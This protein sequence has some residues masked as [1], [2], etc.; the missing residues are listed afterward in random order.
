MTCN[1]M[2]PGE[3]VEKLQWDT[4]TDTHNMLIS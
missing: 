2:M 4:H 3:I 1:A